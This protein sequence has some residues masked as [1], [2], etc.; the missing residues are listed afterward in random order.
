MTHAQAPTRPGKIIWLVLLTGWAVCSAFAA[1]LQQEYR[2]TKWETEDGLPENSATAMVQTPDGYLWFG[3]LNGLVRFDGFKFTTFNPLNTPELPGGEIASLYLHPSGRM[4]IST[5]KGLASWQDGQWKR[6]GQNPHWANRVVRSFAGNATG[7]LC[8]T[9]LDGAVCEI[10][11][12]EIIELPKP[13]V[14]RAPHAHMDA[15]GTIWALSEEFAGYWDGQRWVAVAATLNLTNSFRCAATARDGGLWILKQARLIKLQAGRITESRGLHDAVNQVWAMAEDADGTLWAAG[16]RAGLFRIATN[17]AVAHFRMQDGLT[18]NAL[19]FAQRDR[20]ENLWVGTSGGGLMRLRPRTFQTFDT[21]KSLPTRVVRSVS[22]D[23]SGVMLLGTHGGG[24]RRLAA[25]GKVSTV[26]RTK[27]TEGYVQAVLADRQQRT[28]IS[29]HNEGLAVVEAGQER[30]LPIEDTGGRRIAALFEDA[31]GRVWI[32]G[33]DAV[34]RF[35]NGQFQRVNTDAGKAVSS[36]RCFAEN[37]RDGS[38]WAVS[39]RG[40]FRFA[41]GQFQP[42][43]GPGGKPLA[44][45]I[46]LRFE[47]DGTLWV[48]TKNRGLLRLR[49]EVWAGLGQSAGLPSD[50]ITSVLED[51]LGYFWIASNRG[52]A[53]AAKTACHAVADGQR[54]ELNAQVFNGSD[55]LASVE[56][57]AGVQPNATTDSHGRLWFATLK[58]VAVVDPRQVRLHTNPPPVFI[59][60]ITYR[61][62]HGEYHELPYA[63]GQTEL[64]APPGTERLAIYFTGINHSA[65]EK[66][67]FSYTTDVAGGRWT[68]VSDRRVIAVPTPKPGQTRF[69]LK[70]ANGD[71]VWNETG[72][73]LAFTVPPFYWQT[74]WF[75]VL[76]GLAVVVGIGG[77][78]WRVQRQE[79]RQQRRE[80]ARERSLA[81]ERAQLAATLAANHE[82]AV[83]QRAAVASL[84]TDSELNGPELDVALRRLTEILSASLQV[85]RASVWLMSDDGREMRCAELF[86]T[87]PRRHSAGLVLRAA[88]Y[89]RY[90]LALQLEARVDADDAVNDPRTSEFA[91]GYLRPLGI[92]SML[93]AVLLKDGQ[94]AGVVCLEHTGAARHWEADEQSFANTAAA[95]VAQILAT[96]QRRQAERRLASF[97]NLGQ[98]LNAV[99]DVKPAGRLIVE[100]ADELFGWD[101]ST[102]VLYD[103]ATDRCRPAFNMDVVNG[104]RVEVPPAY[105]E[106]PPTPLLRR[107]MERGSELTLREESPAMAADSVP[108]GDLSRPSASL[109]FVPVRD[110]QKV[111]GVLSIQS[112]QR[113]AY[114]RADLAA[115][116]AL[117]DHCGGALARIQ[118]REAQRASEAKYR[119]L[120][121]RMGEGLIQVDEGDIIRFVNPQICQMLGYA[122]AEMLGQSATTLLIRAED[123]AE[124]AERN[125]QRARGIAAG[126]EIQLRHKSGEFLLVWLS[127]TSMTSPE[128]RPAG[129]MAI[130]TDITERKRTEAALQ[131]MSHSVDHAGDSIFW[132]SREG[133]ILYVNDAACTGRGYTR[134][135]LLGM[136]I[137]ELDPDYQPGIWSSH[138]E[139]LKLRRTVT[140]ETRHRAKDGRVFPIEVNANYVHLNGQEFNFASV[141]DIT[142]RKR[143]EQRVRESEQLLDRVVRN[144]NDVLIVD[145][146]AGRVVFANQKFFELFGIPDHRLEGIRLE[147]YVAPE[148]RAR[149]RELHDRRVRGEPV[150]DHF[151]C[152]GLRHDGT[153]VWIE[154]SVVLVLEQ[155]RIVGTQSVFRDITTRRS[156]EEQLRQSQKME[157]IG[158]LAGGIAHDFNNILGAIVGNVELA[159]TMPPD[160]P[161]L[162]VSLNAIHTASQRAAGLVKQILAFSRRQEQQRQPLQMAVLVREAIKLLRATV[163]A[164]VQFEHQLDAVPTVL[165]DPSAIHQVAMNLCTNAWHALGDRPGVIRV[166]LAATTV[167]ADLAQRHPELRP[168]PYVRLTVADTGCGMDAATLAHIFE[169][170]FTTKPVG[171]GTGLGLAVVHGIMRTHDGGIVVTSEPGVG[172][173]FGLYFPVFEASAPESLAP[174]DPLPNGSGEHILFVDDEPAL[175]KV[176]RNILLRMGYRV[177]LVSSPTEALASFL[178]Q[179]GQFDLVITDNNMPGMSGTQL[180]TQILAS[181]P[182]Q[183]IILTTGFSANITEETAR[184]L[185]FAGLLPKP[186][187]MR[188]LSE[189]VQAVLQAAKS[190]R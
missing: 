97:A 150:P 32:G 25:D 20:E 42:V 46:C 88:D 148:W 12:E 86:E 73:S 34:V 129:S 64:V 127:A 33:N 69:R 105:T 80:L 10:R 131:M 179:P 72:V 38:L 160:D 61:D 1:P 50:T 139:D 3:T 120:I 119:T 102:L 189:A 184:A 171:S 5:D 8:A 112:Y 22:E 113:L 141:R 85:E 187:N 29:L 170:F 101:A 78:V 83:R 14:I 77:T 9:S 186:Y 168:G 122:E 124:L 180:G 89:P 98:R 55:G 45:G 142:E 128:G 133:R 36:V 57:A 39:E 169:P 100:V 6:H 154:V 65:P 94:V 123:H 176:G 92:T 76:A 4:W 178:A 137:F 132:V 149:Q 19:R 152:E 81:G 107:V 158:Q 49:N 136:T 51:G 164:S 181:Y 43:N 130:I 53:R 175:G 95:L 96:S 121:E 155:G 151:E 109:M 60:R 24:A 185:G 99:T 115:L 110:G 18:Y 30:R 54:T 41:A 138:W 71:G 125:R 75:R 93:D 17:G 91:A 108:F 79:L 13:P 82:R 156:L 183:R 104:Q 27:P 147:D 90:W 2:I 37:A 144:I 74:L 40:L 153:R 157:A 68:D 118:S 116:Q 26:L 177:T 23:R 190:P 114:T 135:E 44:E 28:W 35:E 163:P 145:D 146:I 106:Q 21:E 15:A 47:A 31:A 143:A 117:A 126:Y 52:I 188:S 140:L 134:E 84:V 48:G 167:D 59:E 159:R 165:A 173:T 111:I 62:H 103:A 162:A 7:A 58:G 56:C 87:S 172:T 174:S 70:A 63:R 67:R 166:E 66:I 16:V 161:E 11:G 182:G